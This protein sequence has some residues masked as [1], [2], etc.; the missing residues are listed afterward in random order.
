LTIKNFNR[1]VKQRIG[2]K[3]TIPP[4]DKLRNIPQA[5]S[6]LDLTPMVPGLNFLIDFTLKSG[7]P[8]TN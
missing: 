3:E 2:L 6:I 5:S 4:V 7:L 8:V 1:R